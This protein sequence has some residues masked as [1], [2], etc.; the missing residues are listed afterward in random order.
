MDN[1]R[2]DLVDG[3]DDKS[4]DQG[5]HLSFRILSLFSP[6][7]TT[8]L[9]VVATVL[10]TLHQKS[11]IS[12]NNPKNVME[13]DPNIRRKLRIRTPAEHWRLPS[14]YPKWEPVALP[15]CCASKLVHTRSRRFSYRFSTSCSDD[16]EEKPRYF[17]PGVGLTPDDLKN[18]LLETSG[19]IILFGDSLMR[20]WFEQLSC[21]L[22]AMESW[23][24]FAKSPID[25]NRGIFENQMT[26]LLLKTL[27]NWQKRGN[28]GEKG[29][30]SAFGS[31]ELNSAD[32]FSISPVFK[33][34]MLQYTN[35]LEISE[36]K[37]LLYF[38]H[39]M[40]PRGFHRDPPLFVI[41]LGLHYN[42]P[43]MPNGYDDNDLKDHLTDVIKT[44]RHLGA[45]CI[46]RETSPQHFNMTSGNGLFANV[47]NRSCMT[48]P[49]ATF[50]Q[51]SN[52]RNQIL[53]QV[54][55]EVGQGIFHEGFVTVMPIFRRM[56]GLNTNHKNPEDCTHWK[57]DPEPWEP[58][59][60]SLTRMLQSLAETAQS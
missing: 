50:G 52:W 51:L 23:T 47:H 60:I 1:L 19:D 37:D 58:W 22:G 54:L 59:H 40:Y 31:F 30:Y 10:F 42:I 32:K 2:D 5:R 41:N 26:E 15:N 34:I 17:G 28:F 7:R 57:F 14:E 44:C 39:T 38:Y 3:R 8:F 20:Q 16:N 21:Y 56:A 18:A 29:G 25:H 53:Y 6:L 27:P 9:V 13:D 33:R 49:P 45:R 35:P 11:F 24:G 55:D 46:L 4:R 48:E 43:P 12:Q 36:M